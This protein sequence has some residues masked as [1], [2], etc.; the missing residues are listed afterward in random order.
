MSL[1]DTYTPIYDMVAKAKN[2]LF[3]H[4]HSMKIFTVKP[5]HVHVLHADGIA[6][7]FK[8]LFYIDKEYYR[9]ELYEICYEDNREE[10]SVIYN[11]KIYRMTYTHNSKINIEQ[12]TN[13][14]D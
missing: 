14:S 2:L 8:V 5:E 10:L 11:I 13:D 3:H 12:L 1:I 9:N 4:L 7:C 6:N